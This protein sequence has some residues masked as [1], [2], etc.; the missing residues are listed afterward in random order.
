MDLSVE[1]GDRLL[2]QNRYDEADQHFEAAASARPNDPEPLAG[3]VRVG[4][5]RKDMEEL[6]ARLERFLCLC[7][8][9]LDEKANLVQVIARRG[10]QKRAES[11]LPSLLALAERVHFNRVTGQRLLHLI[12]FCFRGS[13]WSEAMIRLRDRVIE[14]SA[15]AAI[16]GTDASLPG[17]DADTADSSDS[18]HSPLQILLCEIYLALGDHDAFCRSVASLPSGAGGK[19][20]LRDLLRVRDKIVSPNF[21]DFEREKVFGIGLSRTG[22]T[23]LNTALNRLGFHSIH[24]SNPMTMDLIGQSDFVLYDAFTDISVSSQFESLYHAFPNSKFVFTT[25]DAESWETSITRHYLRNAGEDS[26]DGVARSASRWKF[27][28]KASFVHHGVY[29]AF[30]NWLDAREAYYRRVHDFFRDK[31]KER[32][33]EMNIVDGD[34]YEKLCPFLGVSDPG[35]PFPN[36]NSGALPAAVSAQR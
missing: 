30:D 31:P 32:F 11:E 16:C 26:I 28:N 12:Q 14:C 20:Q 19:R 34:G 24:W 7:P 2:E 35:K 36:S 22:T 6:R 18:A 33:L 27:R 3:L 21:P 10:D 9:S 29:G 5:K 25:R 13:Q 4:R 1:T 8:D 23:S 15:E 17:N